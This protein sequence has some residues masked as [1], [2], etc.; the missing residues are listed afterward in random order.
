LRRSAT[1]T[2]AGCR[3][4]QNPPVIHEAAFDELDARTLYAI[5]R[6]RAEVFVV[7]QDCPYLDP[8]GRDQ[9]ARHLWIEQDGAVVAY[10]R[11]LPGKLGRVV[12]HP[13]ARGTGLA[14]ELVRRA[15][16]LADRPVRIDAQSRLGPWYGTFGWVQDGDEFLEDGI[17]HIPMRLD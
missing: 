11:I 8:D 16:E 14:T 2:V 9:D 6:L 7:E 5:L 10:L 3:K 4:N 12:T 15:L 13:T 17:A 1:K